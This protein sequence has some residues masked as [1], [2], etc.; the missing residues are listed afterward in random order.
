MRVSARRRRG[1]RA[2]S[3]ETSF[4]KATPTSSTRWVSAAV[5]VGRRRTVDLFE[6]RNAVEG[7]LFAASGIIFWAVALAAVWLVLQRRLHLSDEGAGDRDVARS[8]IRQGG[9]SLSWM[10]LWEPNK[11]WFAPDGRGGVAYQLHGNVALTLAGPFGPAAFR[12]DTAAVAKAA[13]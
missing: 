2:R 6:G 9:D 13:E 12:E 5:D 4:L 1:S 7:F 8:L 10:A 11:Y 3:L